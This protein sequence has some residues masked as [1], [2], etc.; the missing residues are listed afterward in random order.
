MIR[1]VVIGPDR[2]LCDRLQSALTSSRKVAIARRVDGYVSSTELVRLLRAAAPEVVFLGVESMEQAAETAQAIA[3]EAPGTQVVAVSRTCDASTL[4]EAMRAGMREFLSPPFE[5]GP[6]A[7]TLA[8]IESLLAQHPPSIDS[9]DAVY[10]FLPAKAGVGTT[11]IAVNTAL[12]LA[13][14][15]ENETLLLDLDLNSGLVGFMMLLQ[16]QYSMLDAV[17]NALE[18]DENLWTKIITKA[19]KLDVIPVGQMSPGFRIEPTQIRHLVGFAQRNY[20]TICVDLSGMMEK[21]SIDVLHESKRIFLVSTAELPSLHL[22]REKLN[23]LRS[24]DLAGRVSILLNR[25]HKRHQISVEEMEKL[26]GLPIHMTFPNDYT[27]VHKA[28][29]AGKP[30]DVGSELGR[31]Y[32]ELAETM[33]TVRP[34]PPSEKRKAGRLLGS[35]LGRNTEAGVV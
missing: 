12:A 14:Q 10:S 35:L 18:M 4:L 9:T 17:E 3:A 29:T 32:R 2:E 25:S 28:L 11:T 24:Q 19:G 33:L 27:G 6:M 34:G 5:P 13:S 31:K 8:R 1:G 16:S 22:A 30:V 23:Y 21:Y 26:F 20:R 7:E 15:P